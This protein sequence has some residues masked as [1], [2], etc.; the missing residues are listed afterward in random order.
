[1][2]LDPAEEWT[3]E[4][5]FIRSRSKNTPL[6]GARFTGRVQGVFLEGKWQSAV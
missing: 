6:L 2:L 3:F 1:V 4:K 5:R